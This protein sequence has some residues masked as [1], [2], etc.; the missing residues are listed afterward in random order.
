MFEHNVSFGQFGLG[1]IGSPPFVLALVG[2]PVTL[3]CHDLQPH[4]KPARLSRCEQL[5]TPVYQ[6][7]HAPSPGVQVLTPGHRELRFPS[8][9]HR[10]FPFV[11][12][13][14]EMYGYTV[15]IATWVVLLFD[16]C[17]AV[18]VRRMLRWH[19]IVG[20]LLHGAMLVLWLIG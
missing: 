16:T 15:N 10:F 20:T 9:L 14:I 2:T 5:P 13:S 19:D 6:Y 18:A 1:G 17:G 8:R 7:P 4:R 12:A 11:L 3:F